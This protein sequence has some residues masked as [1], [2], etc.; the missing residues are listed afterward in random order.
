MAQLK[1]NLLN[2]RVCRAVF[3]V[4]LGFFCIF[5]LKAANSALNTYNFLI[6]IWFLCCR[7]KCQSG[8]VKNWIC[9]LIFQTESSVYQIFF[10]CCSE[11]IE[12]LVLI[13]LL[14]K[15]TQICKIFW[16]LSLLSP[17]V[18]SLIHHSQHSQAP[19]AGDFSHGWLHRAGCKSV[20]RVLLSALIRLKEVALISP[21]LCGHNYVCSQN[22]L[23][24][25][26]NK[27]TVSVS[28]QSDSITPWVL[29]SGGAS[30]VTGTPSPEALLLHV[31][32]LFRWI[33]L[34]DFVFAQKY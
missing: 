6:L 32:C 26:L 29:C 10:C 20:A 33:F 3:V 1:H 18:T 15:L 19:P 25:E 27:V 23:R 11:K 22:D 8:S 30:T 12:N 7:R 13:L 21:V 28:S 24:G 17:F 9:S 14:M 5:F 16:E 2:S 31:P 4:F 34:M